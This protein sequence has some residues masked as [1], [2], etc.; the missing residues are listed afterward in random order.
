MV[1]TGTESKVPAGGEKAPATGTAGGSSQAAEVSGGADRRRPQNPRSTQNRRSPLGDVVSSLVGDD[2]PVAI[3]FYDGGRLGP[4]DPPATV[5]VRSPAAVS[6]ILTAPGELGFAR[7]YVAGDIELEGDI[8]SVLELRHRLPSPKLTASQWLA[9]LRVVGPLALR[10]LPAPP[11]EAR[12][13]GRL[14]SL[15]RDAESVSHHYD[16]SNE[17]YEMVLGPA[18][19]YSCALFGGAGTTLEQ[20]QWAKLELICQK[21][22]L[23][24]GMRLLDV[25]CGWGSM[26]IHAARNHGVE[27]VGVTLSKQ[28]A[29]WA[30]QKVAALGLA[31]RVDIRVQDYRSVQ[32]ERFDAIS[33]IG[34]SEHVGA[35]ELPTYFAKLRGLLDDGGRLLNHAITRRPGEDSAISPRSFMSRYVFPDAALVEV[36]EVI[37]AMQS[38]GF[39][40]QH[41]E[42]L[43]LHYARTL[44][45]WVSNLEANWDEC[46]A[47]AGLARARIW[48]LYMAGSALGF[49]DGRISIAQVLGTPLGVNEIPMRPDW[50]ASPEPPE[51]PFEEHAAAK[52]TGVPTPGMGEVTGSS[53][54]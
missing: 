46:V 7:A 11:E 51:V 28:Q 22:A 54:A 32:G 4:A 10:P 19:V 14:H 27:A 29:E 31:D 20:A 9:A 52:A 2:L 23:E 47:E 3:R 39:E 42:S 33:S 37:T 48:R 41:A 8:Y 26:A 13:K 44:R 5:E 25:G 36:G 18:M 34:M 17:F 12:Q 49:E 6:R 24:P 50:A 30:R 35:S 40:V 15:R 43:R 45:H 16:V 38:A 53:R 21:L 1:D